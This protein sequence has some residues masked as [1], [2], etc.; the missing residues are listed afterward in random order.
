MT[1]QCRTY[2]YDA[3]PMNFQPVKYVINRF[4]LRRQSLIAPTAHLGLQL[5]V[6]TEDV[7]G[8]HLYKYGTH[9]P[10]TSE[11]LKHYLKFQDGDVAI[12]IGA[13]IGWYSLI[14]DRIA[15]ERKVDIFAFEP[16]PTNFDLLTE[17]ISRNSATRVSIVQCAV[18]DVTGH[19]TLHLYNK[20]NRGRHSLLAIHDGETVD[21]NT[22]TLDEFWKSSSLGARLPRFIKMDIEG[23]EFMALRGA[24]SVLSRCPMVMLE[25]SPGYMKAASIAPGE[26]VDLMLGQGFNLRS[27]DKQTDLFWLRD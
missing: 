5:R 17:N 7:V 23:F 21:V 3:L 1:L 15:G 19:Q 13:N 11:F 20:S 9:E 14:L 12:D 16:D 27:S 6:K 26:L 25:Y 2:S 18:A 10:A 24:T 22:V 4:I 8:R